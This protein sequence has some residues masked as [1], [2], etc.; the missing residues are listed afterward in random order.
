MKKALYACIAVFLG[1]TSFA[2]ANPVITHSLETQAEY[3]Y[4]RAPQFNMPIP[5]LRYKIQP[6]TLTRKIAQFLSRSVFLQEAFQRI[7]PGTAF[8]KTEIS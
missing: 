7:L 4:N 3:S 1:S 2:V 6:I 5:G 8:W